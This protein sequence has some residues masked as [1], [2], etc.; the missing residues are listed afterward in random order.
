MKISIAY[1][2]LLLLIISKANAQVELKKDLER[3]LKEAKHDTIRVWAMAKLCNYYKFSNPDS[4]LFYG[5]KAI[6]LA[7]KIEYPNGQLEAMRFLVL[8]Y[9]ST[10]NEIKATRLYLKGLKLAR[11]YHLILQE[12]LLLTVVGKMQFDVGNDVGALS[13]FKLSAQLFDECGSDSLIALSEA[14]IG[15]VYSKMNKT[16]SALY[17][18]QNALNDQRK[19]AWIINIANKRLGEVYSHSGK[20]ELAL[21]HYKNALYTENEDDFNSWIYLS[22]AE[23][24]H[25]MGFIDS[26]I[27]YTQKVLQIGKQGGVYTS[28][29][30]ACSFLT[31]LYEKTDLNKSF[32][33]SKMTIL[34]KD[35]L[36]NLVKRTSFQDYADFD[37]IESQAELDRAKSDYRNRLRTNAFLGSTFTLVVISLLLFRNNRQKQ[38]AKKEIE[39]AFVQ[40]KT[41]QAQL[42]QSEKMASLGQLVAG[43]AHEINTPLG[44][45]KASAGIMADSNL[46]V[47]N[48]FPALLLQLDTE[49]QKLLFEMINTAA[50]GMQVLDSKN[51]RIYKKQLAELLRNNGIEKSENIADTLVDIGLHDHVERF[52]PLLQMKELQVL[53]AVYNLS[54]MM[55]N[56][57]NIRL[58]V[59][60]VGKTVFALKNYAHNSHSEEKVKTNVTEGIET[61]LTIYQ[62]RLKNGIQVT[63][64][65]GPVPLID[66]WPDE[67]NQVWTNLITNAIDSMDGKGELTLQV[68][69]G[70][71]LLNNRP[72]VVV[73]IKDT[74][75]G[76]PEE[77]RPK[78]FEAF[79]TTKPMGEGSGLGL[80][81][82]KEI[83]TKHDGE[84]T[85]ESTPGKG[86]TFT[87]YIPVT[88]HN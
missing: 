2:L 53:Q 18:C 19:A 8:L 63:R 48:D 1:I 9:S 29:I 87:V 20:L 12:G 31:E 15:L 26:S 68:G 75:T 64:N 35:S 10:G 47:M 88:M 58:A 84:I 50:G 46:K 65:F 7:E 33:Y 56:S 5:Y 45:I 57:R 17:Y 34:Y 16:D 73:K 52:I 40:L 61:I 30:E 85:I 11:Q 23:L 37:K 67:L 39:Q 32:E 82:A 28:I 72:C 83:I 71:M 4:A 38:K 78:I 49:K 81:I 70:N 79:F 86:S 55:Q 13:S 80:Y 66:A 14:G 21:I 43:I 69:M 59:E 27:F 41:A 74:G 62:N 36:L 3:Q 25:K 77:I 54:L 42:I 51:E 60:R 22:I 6:S 24:F 76:I 44:A